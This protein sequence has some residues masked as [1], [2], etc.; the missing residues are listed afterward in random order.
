MNNTVVFCIVMFLVVIL[1]SIQCRSDH[2]KQLRPTRGFIK[3]LTLG[4]ARGFGKR[5]VNMH[6]VNKWVLTITLLMSLYRI[7]FIFKRFVLEIILRFSY[8]ISSTISTRDDNKLKKSLV[9]ILQRV[10]PFLEAIYAL[11]HSMYIHYPIDK[12]LSAAVSK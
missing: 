11:L 3:E 10:S 9:S 1:S 6:T 7:K 5:A 12:Y 4:T 8:T 2:S